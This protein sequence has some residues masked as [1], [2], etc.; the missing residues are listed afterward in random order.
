MN[1]ATGACLFAV[2]YL[3]HTPLGEGYC[4]VVAVVALVASCEELL[5]HLLKKQY[6]GN[7]KTVLSVLRNK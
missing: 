3:L 2:P 1:K 7:T 5:L 4:W 6:D